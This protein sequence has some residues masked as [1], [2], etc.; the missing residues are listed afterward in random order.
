MRR[1]SLLL[2]FAFH[3][4]A[5]AA[6]WFALAPEPTVAQAPP[7]LVF[8]TPPPAPQP[9]ALP[10]APALPAGPAPAVDAPEAFPDE[11]E[12]PPEPG[13]PERLP[14][15]DRPRMAKLSRPLLARPATQEPAPRPAPREPGPEAVVSTA[16]RPLA[17]NR[18]DVPYPLRAKRRGHEGTVVLR[19]EVSVA[20][21]AKRIDVARSSG[22]P[23]L[24][25]AAVRAV[26]RWRF[27]PA[28]RDGRPVAATVRIPI[29]FRLEG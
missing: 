7:A 21:E 23:S 19:V 9:D 10:A 26:R 15:L 4:A 25:R 28:T 3:A 13:R 5:L 1:N 18:P 20:G 27:V 17:A 11:P 24:D 8:R 6:A 22:H 16:A 29:E 14:A 2:S 12:P